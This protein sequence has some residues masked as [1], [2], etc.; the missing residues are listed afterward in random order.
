MFLCKAQVADWQI[1]APPT[2]SITSLNKGRI[3]SQHMDAEI[4]TIFDAG[5]HLGPEDFKKYK[6]FT[7]VFQ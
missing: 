3:Q 6:K 4:K 1:S 2:L 7:I 5:H